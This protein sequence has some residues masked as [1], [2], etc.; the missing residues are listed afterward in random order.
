MPEPKEFPAPAGL[1]DRATALWHG[2]VPSRAVSHGRRALI[3]EALR[4]LDR[5]DEAAA[6]VNRDGLSFTTETT[7][8]V[9]IHPAVR[10]EREARQMF[11]KIW[12][13]MHLDWSQADH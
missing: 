4:A 2:V 12:S 5:A 6:I 13:G 8:A 3:E 1:S 7:G 9:H 11:A 10:I